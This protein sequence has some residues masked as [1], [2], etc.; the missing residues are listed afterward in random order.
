VYGEGGTPYFVFDDERSHEKEKGV[1][2]DP[3]HAI[4]IIHFDTHGNTD[5]MDWEGEKWTVT[6]AN[7]DGDKEFDY[8]GDIERIFPKL[9]GLSKLFTFRS[10]DPQEKK[11]YEI[12]NKYNENLYDLNMKHLNRE[13]SIFK[14]SDIEN[15]NIKLIDELLN[16]KLKIKIAEFFAEDLSPSGVRRAMRGGNNGITLYITY[17]YIDENEVNQRIERYR[18]NLENRKDIGDHV[19]IKTYDEP[20]DDKMRE[21][22]THAKNL[23]F[24]F[25]NELNK[26]YIKESSLPQNNHRTIVEDF[27]SFVCELLDIKNRPEVDILDKPIK[28]GDQP[29]FGAY[30]PNNHHIM[31]C[32]G[33]RHLLD[34]LR[35][36]AHEM[37][38]FKQNENGEIKDGDGNTGSK[39]ENEANTTAGIIMREY[40]KLHPELF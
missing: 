40:G 7:N 36:L 33:N 17:Y 1:W 23:Y 3:N 29:S 5:G 25:K 21:Y 31:V 32:F 28:N 34:A 8:F 38:H 30:D 10:T 26:I 6:N 24:S 13:N 22:L 37:T 14:W 27:V 2:E 12:I 20:V 19:S 16:N 18:K 9:K 4:V 15:I 11:E 35:T 39:I